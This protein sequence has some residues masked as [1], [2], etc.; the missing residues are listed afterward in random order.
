MF[1]SKLLNIMQQLFSSMESAFY[2]LISTSSFDHILILLLF[3]FCFQLSDWKKYLS[4]FLAISIGSVVGF[5]LAVFQVTFF[6]VSII[7][8]IMAI[9]VCVTGL[10]LMISSNISANTIR[11][12]FFVIIGL[13]V[14]TGISLHYFKMFGR[15]L[16]FYTLAGYSLGS[17]I[18]YLT[19]SI[20]GLLLSSIIVSLFRT[21]RRSFSIAAS[22]I[23]IGIALVIIYM[24]Y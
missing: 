18:G 12:N 1:G 15:G 17:L 11:Y 24:R 23:G 20:I 8:L 14:G 21:D 9:G 22:G 10:H 13:L 6:S 4:L 2:Y 3:G 16:Q 19:I 7:K 5:L